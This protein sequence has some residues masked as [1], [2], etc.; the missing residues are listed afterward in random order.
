MPPAF[1]TDVAYSLG[2]SYWSINGNSSFFKVF[3]F[4]KSVTQIHKSENK[5]SLIPFVCLRNAVNCS[6]MY[7]FSL[8]IYHRHK[9][10]DNTLFAIF[11]ELFYHDNL[12]LVNYI[13]SG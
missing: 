9:I 1:Y 4:I 10:L 5:M 13:P 7:L 3:S 8:W 12:I 11:N 2:A 6:K